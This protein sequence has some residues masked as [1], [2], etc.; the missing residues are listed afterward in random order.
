MQN[1][2]LTNGS[3]ALKLD[4]FTTFINNK[5]YSEDTKRTYLYGMKSYWAHGF[6]E[7]NLQNG[8]LYRQMLID[9]GKKPKTINIL[10]FS[11]NVYAKWAGLGF[12][13]KDMRINDEPFVS[14]GMDLDDYH[15]LVDNLLRDGNYKWYVV[16]KLLAATGMRIGEAVQVTFGDLRRGHCS[17]LGKGGKYREVFFSHILRETLYAYTKDKGDDEK[18]VPADK[19]YVRTCFARIKRKYGLE[20]SLSPHDLRRFFARQMFE[21]TGDIVLIKG[22]LGHESVRTTSLYV[23]KTHMKA[24]EMYNHAQNW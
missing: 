6:T 10:V 13:I 24:M 15:T 16:I 2:T 12:F 21:A 7:V 23:R 11:L 18:V 20:F 3:S 4:E 5:D 9:E 14:N 8:L 19:K 22:L 1:L 17:I